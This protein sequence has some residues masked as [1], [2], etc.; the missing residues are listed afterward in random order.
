[1]LFLVKIRQWEKS[2]MLYV[3]TIVSHVLQSCDTVIF[4]IDFSE[5]MMAFYLKLTFFFFKE[6]L[7]LFEFIHIYRRILE[8]RKF[9]S[10]VHR[11]LCPNEMLVFDAP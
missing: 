11:F 8:Q 6:Y 4:G 10:C 3:K 7:V 1:M 5:F 2:N 9:I